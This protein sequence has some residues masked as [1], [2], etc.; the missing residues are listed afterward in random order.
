MG[1]IRHSASLYL[2]QNLKYEH[3]ERIWLKYF[4]A[5]SRLLAPGWYIKQPIS[6]N[7]LK[8]RKLTNTN[9]AVIVLLFD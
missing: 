5:P 4:A 3:K 7:G 1:N 9:V 6:L 2:D 8:I